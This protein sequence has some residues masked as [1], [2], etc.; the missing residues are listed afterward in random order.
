MLAVAGCVQTGPS[1]NRIARDQTEDAVYRAVLAAEARELA[2]VESLFVQ[3]DV[4]ARY[5]SADAARSAAAGMTLRID[6]TR[7]VSSELLLAY[8]MA[9]VT[10]RRIRLPSTLEQHRVVAA[11]AAPR[12]PSTHLRYVRWLSRVGVNARGD[13]ALVQVS[14]ICGM[15]CGQ[16]AMMLV[17]YDR[18]RW[19]VAKE[20][21]SWQH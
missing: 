1:P 21:A 16:G 2:P 3:R 14:T 13:S 4:E 6:L 18:G 10:N 5:P 20:L 15:V 7:R 11:D 8:T 9:N 17:V 19:Q 12:A